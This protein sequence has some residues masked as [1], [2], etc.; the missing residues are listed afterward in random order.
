[1]LDV[2]IRH[3]VHT[4]EPRNKQNRHTYPITYAL[5]KNYK[6]RDCDTT[7]DGW[8]ATAS[9]GDSHS[10]SWNVFLCVL[11]PD[12]KKVAANSSSS[13]FH[14]MPIT[15]PK[16]QNQQNWLHHLPLT[17]KP[18]SYESPRLPACTPK[19]NIIIKVTAKNSSTVAITFLPE[20][21]H[22]QHY[23]G[24]QK[25]VLLRGNP[26]PSLQKDFS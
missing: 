11:P 21:T 6:V 25:W 23:P 18:T 22:I 5:G 12:S 3:A 2:L 7:M 9:H 13:V 20:A 16:L 26:S 17:S 10:L 24:R 1:M 14:T 8:V 4:T 15:V 19:Q